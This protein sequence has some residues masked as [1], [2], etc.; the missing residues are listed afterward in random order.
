MLGFIK[1]D[2][3]IIKGNLKYLTIILVIYMVMGITGQMDMSYVVTFMSGVLTI[4]VFRYDDF[5][6]WDAY[7]ATLPNGRKNSVRAKY[8]A[9][10]IIL[11]SLTIFTTVFSLVI[12]LLKSESIIFETI[13]T[14][15]AS[16]L[17]GTIIFITL[18][19]PI[20]YKFGTEK[21]AIVFF[22]IFFGIIILGGLIVS[23]IDF[24]SILK[25][26]DFLKDYFV[27]ILIAVVALFLFLSY[28][29]SIRFE[30]KKEF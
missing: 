5:N 12:T 14:S 6:H 17:L 27:A 16:N 19:Y 11:L 4:T 2:L 9:T 15:L 30:M 28:K 25:S 20:I 7:A 13:L 24:A 10:I 18:M 29:L 1:K 22:A 3:S 26:L 8:L 23:N 21:A